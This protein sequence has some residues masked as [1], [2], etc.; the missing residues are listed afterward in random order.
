[1]KPMPFS[2]WLAKG[3]SCACWKV[4][5]S[6]LRAGSSPD[7]VLTLDVGGDAIASMRTIEVALAAAG[8][9]GRC[10]VRP[11]ARIAGA[12]LVAERARLGLQPFQRIAG[13]IVNASSE[14]VKPDMATENED[15]DVED[16]DVEDDVEDWPEASAA[17]E[18]ADAGAAE[19]AS[20]RAGAKVASYA[21]RQAKA[22]ADRAE[23]EARAAEARARAR[24]FQAQA[25][26]ASG[27]S[28]VQGSPDASPLVALLVEQM[29]EQQRQVAAM[30]QRLAAPAPAPAKNPLEELKG[31]LALV[32]AIRELFQDAGGGGDAPEP[33]GAA[34]T[35]REIRHLA[36]ELR[37]LLPTAP[38]APAPA[39]ASALSPALGIAAPPASFS[40]S[41]EAA[42]AQRIDAESRRRVR[43]FLE[44]IIG[45]LSRGSEADAVG[46]ALWSDVGMLP[47]PVRA[48]I[49][50]EGAT[51]GAVLDTC[52][53]FLEPEELAQ[54][55]PYLA[56]AAV[57]E[58][59][60]QL[61]ASLGAA[62]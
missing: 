4:Q 40:P 46:D 47:A 12:G 59:C 20:A 45:E 50:A 48:A 23:A 26:A 36:A 13:S 60:A 37:P 56:D 16:D 34:A 41:N 53:P 49:R 39:S 32:S 44:A 25:A 3:P 57:A 19:V 28:A 17:V 30:L 15:D 62:D 58:W 61:L 27:G 55:R 29:R 52:A 42:P 43:E 1:M 33:S 35:L 7:Q 38:P 51:V 22:E 5:A 14:G 21:A 18:S 8:L 9:S 24:Q 6:E 54:V 2:E 10:F 11:V 31:Q